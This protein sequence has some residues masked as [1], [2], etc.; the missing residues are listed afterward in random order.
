MKKRGFTATA[1][2]NNA[3]SEVPLGFEEND[4]LFSVLMHEIYHNIYDGQSLALKQD[5]RSWFANNTSPNSQY[6][7]LLLNETLATALGNGHVHEQLNGKPNEGIWYNMK[8]INLMA[9]QMYPL[10]K[11]YLAEKRTMDKDFVD[12]YIALYDKHFPDWTKELDNLFSNRFV[13]ADNHEDLAFFNKNYRFP[14]FSMSS[15]PLDQYALGKMRETPITKVIVIS[16]DHKNRLQLV[17]STFPE[18]KKWKYSARQEFVYM[19]QLKDK[20]KL[21]VVNKHQSTLSEL[22]DQTFG[23][24]KVQ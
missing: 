4:V 3:I 6:A 2:L 12:R 21:L 19:V 5:I 24:D 10:V 23:R 9:K 8:Y 13:I 18:L 16:S 11:Q 20:T 14:G 7:L 15:V 1:F 22:I 17:K